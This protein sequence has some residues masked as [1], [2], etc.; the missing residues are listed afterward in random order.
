MSNTPIS[1]VFMPNT[2]LKVTAQLHREYLLAE[3][4]G[5]KLFLL[6]SIE[7]TEQALAIQPHVSL[8]VVVDTS[9]SMREVVT[10]PTEQSDE[11]TIQDGR[12]YRV[13]YG[14]KTKMD[15]M[16]EALNGLVKSKLLGEFDRMALVKFD[17]QAE[18]LVPFHN[19]YKAMLAE[20]IP[21]LLQ[22]S[23]GTQMGAGMEKAT[24]LLNKVSGS[25]R[26]LLV[27][28]GQTFDQSKVQAQAEILARAQIPVTVVGVGKDVN[29]DLLT[30]IADLTNGQVIDV[31]ADLEEPR[32]PAVRATELPRRLL[33]DLQNATSE[34]VTEVE[35][36]VR[37]V[38]GVL[39][40]R[41]TRVQPVQ[42]EV[43]LHGQGL[44]LG[45]VPRETGAAFVLEFTMP[46]RPAARM[47][48][49]QLGLTY[50]IPQ[51]GVA[52]RHQMPPLDVVVEFTPDETRATELNPH[53]M[54]F[55]GQ[56]NLE[57]LILKATE[58]A[59]YDP[60]QATHTLA[61]ARR[62]TQ[63]LGNEAMTQALDRAIDELVTG[64]TISLGT[65][66]TLK[67]GAKTQTLQT[68]ANLPS[69]QSIRRA[70][71]V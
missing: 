61:L 71:G 2:M 48:M 37:S 25:R 39:L 35:L 1:D 15:V 6:L 16:V 55:V 13:V 22:Y 62:M 68:S 42:T 9:G 45:N 66:K 51:P 12:Q 3:T 46:A 24:H 50:K 70:T 40:N 65:V 47:R 38:R 60:Q 29:T 59:T 11:L 52:E 67:M 69:D 10:E 14:A 7:P 36:N 41:V 5:Q 21:Y 58:Q 63:E 33:G 32:P 26:M 23:G 18:V 54:Q 44:R 31:V 4:T 57:G 64:Q 28:D 53:V 20:R 17:D 49:A 8:A 34:V 56:R 30:H 27:T 43:E 19:A